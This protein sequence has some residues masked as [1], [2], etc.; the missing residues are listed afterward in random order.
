MTVTR[1]RK[2]AYASG[3]A[4]SAKKAP[5]PAAKPAAD[6]A[7]LKNARK[8]ANKTVPSGASVDAFIEAIEHDQ[9][10]TDA[11][12]LLKIMKDATGETPVMWGDS[13]IGFGQ[14]HYRYE[15]GREGDFMNVGFSAR[16]TSLVLYVMGSIPED[17]P[18]R[19]RL[20][21]FTTG[22]ACLYVNKLADVDEKILRKLIRKSYDATVAKW[23]PHER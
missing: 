8:A 15:S 10:R 7:K 11:R 21:K 14:Y 17:D 9:R 3:A 13:I 16:K 5:K 18:L 20:G 4:K 23:G 19:A 22:R 12:A 2:S 6:V 1:K